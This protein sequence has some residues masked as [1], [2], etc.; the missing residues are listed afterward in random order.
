MFT[1]H[2]NYAVLP[3]KCTPE[4]VHFISSLLVIPLKNRDQYLLT[5]RVPQKSLNSGF[6][7]TPKT[8]LRL[9]KKVPWVLGRMM[10]ENFYPIP[11]L[12]VIYFMTS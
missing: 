1:Y 8:I 2:F 9:Q 7:I 6:Y 5:Y 11:T 4:N 3:T 10:L 12:V